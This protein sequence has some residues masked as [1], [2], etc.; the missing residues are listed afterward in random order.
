M[1]EL[2]DTVVWT[3]KTDDIETKQ[4]GYGHVHR[5]PDSRL[6]E[7]NTTWKNVIILF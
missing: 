1:K 6:I 2:G 4:L 3:Y 7:I 5:M